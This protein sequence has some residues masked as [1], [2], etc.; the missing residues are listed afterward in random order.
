MG[1]KNIIDKIQDFENTFSYLVKI[2]ADLKAMTS[3][4][5][6]VL[7]RSSKFRRIKSDVREKF[8]NKYKIKK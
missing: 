6:E 8:N 1:N 7:K 4:S 2:A 3:V 5:T